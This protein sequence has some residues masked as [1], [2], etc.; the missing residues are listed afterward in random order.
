MTEMEKRDT[1]AIFLRALEYTSASQ[2]CSNSSGDATVSHFSRF[3]SSPM[4]T[5][6]KLKIVFITMSSRITVSGCYHYKESFFTFSCNCRKMFAESREEFK[7]KQLQV[8]C[9]N[10][11]IHN[12]KPWSGLLCFSHTLTRPHVSQSAL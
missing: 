3:G 5:K 1:S 12:N 11:S 2:A 7:L 10:L 8:F 6:M 4:K 9:M